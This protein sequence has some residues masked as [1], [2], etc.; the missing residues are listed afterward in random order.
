MK[1]CKQVAGVLAGAVLVLMAGAAQGA[2]DKMAETPYYPLRVGAT[3][4]Y[5]AGGG[6]FSVRV[7]GHEKAGGRMCARVETTNADGK[8]SS[9]EHLYVTAEGVYRQD[10]Q[11]ARRDQASRG[12]VPALGPVQTLDPPLLIL[13]LPPRAGDSW[14]IDSQVRNTTFKGKFKVASEEVKVPA[15]SYKTFRVGSEDLEEAGNKLTVTSYY[16][17][18]AGLV[19]QVLEVERS[20]IVIEL[21]KYEPGK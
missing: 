14:G 16:A 2:E 18:G 7:A 1:A 20:K 9:L 17:E 8:V 3:W 12:G 6:K 13:K 19:K 21:E 10:I 15:G 5:K 4:H 11:G